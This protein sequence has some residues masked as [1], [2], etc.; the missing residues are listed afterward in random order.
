MIKNAIGII[1]KKTA[2]NWVV[3][4]LRELNNDGSKREKI[5]VILYFSDF[6]CNISFEQFH[7]RDVI[8]FHYEKK[9]IDGCNR[10]FV[11]N[12]TT[13][14]TEILS[15]ILRSIVINNV[16]YPAIVEHVNHLTTLNIMFNVEP[17]DIPFKYLKK[18]V[19][20]RYVKLDTCDFN[21]NVSD[22]ECKFN[23]IRLICLTKLSLPVPPCPSFTT[24]LND[25][26]TTNAPSESTTQ[27]YTTLPSE[28]T[29]IAP[30]ESTTQEQENEDLKVLILIL[31]YARLFLFFFIWF[32]I[33]KL[34]FLMF[35]CC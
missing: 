20:A 35:Y 19:I 22:I 34:F 25:N 12:I 32:L 2:N 26:N 24:T 29:T 21:M 17:Y 7:M 18:N 15:G 30:P 6:K 14:K 4:I 28:N 10:I 9:C 13:L 8:Y 5:R 1:T 23:D 31:K 27:E 16:T 3:D 33:I 11:Y